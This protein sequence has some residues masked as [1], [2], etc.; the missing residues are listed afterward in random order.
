MEQLP[1][2]YAYCVRYIFKPCDRWGINAALHKAN[3]TNGVVRLFRKFFLGELR[4][5]AEMGDI[6]T[7]QSIKVGHTA[8]LK[9]LEPG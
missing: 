1:D 4:R 6:P 3:E 7:E 8:R 2:F 9:E 5:E